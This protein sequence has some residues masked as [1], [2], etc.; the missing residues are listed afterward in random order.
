[1]GGELRALGRRLG[2]RTAWSSPAR[3]KRGELAAW[4]AA[5][6]LFVLASGPRGLPQRGARGAGLR[7]AGGRDARWASIPELLGRSPEAGL[8]VPRAAWPRP[9]PRIDGGPGARLGP[10]ARCA[11]ASRRARWRGGGR[12]GRPRSSAAALD[13]GTPRPAPGRRR[14]GRGGGAMKILYHHRTRAGDAQGIHIA[15][16]QRAFRAARPRGGGGRAGRG[17]RPRRRRTRRRRGPRLA[18]LAALA[19]APAAA[20]PGGHGARLQRRGLPPPGAGDPRATAPDF[21]YERY[22]ANT[23]AGA[24]RRAAVTACRWCWR[25]TRRSPARR[26]STT[27]SVFSPR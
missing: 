16:I 12:G 3:R 9:R 17:R 27:G 24:R 4:Y 20:R 26:P 18:R 15:E 7:H 6:D 23:F 22:A 5:A 14:G 10:R 11:R 1:M 21:L 2:S 25:S 19:G 13:G 8:L